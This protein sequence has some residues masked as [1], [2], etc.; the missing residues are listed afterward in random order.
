MRDAKRHCPLVF[1]SASRVPA[2][3]PLTDQQIAR[4]THHIVLKDVGGEGQRKLLAAKVLIVGAGGLGSPAAL[5]L[6]AAGVGT[7]GIV[8]D[9][10]VEISN[11][12][13]QILHGTEDIGH[14]KTDSAEKK[15]KSINPDIRVNAISLRLTKDNALSLFSGYDFIIDGSDNF[16]TKFIINDTCIELQRPFSHGA[17]TAFKGQA[18][19]YVPGSLCLRCIFP[20]P[21][22]PGC[23]LN[24]KGSG[25][26][27]AVAGIIGSIQAAEAMKSIIGK[28]E[29]LLG[30]MLVLDAFSMESRG[31]PLKRGAPCITC[32]GA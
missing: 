7:I 19:T 15:M 10:R 5:Y 8:D 17:V 28:G 3:M 12:Q 20:S 31:I 32:G 21:P 18:F 11:L 23:I 1:T 22:E 14:H 4:Y 2:F 6:A 29:L 13:R 30:R 9:D 16:T 24:C 25:I 27:G 26:I